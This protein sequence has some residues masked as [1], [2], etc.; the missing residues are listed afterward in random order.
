[1][2]FGIGTSMRRRGEAGRRFTRSLVPALALSLL[3]AG[4]LAPV[5]QAEDGKGLGRPDV[6][7]QRV[8]KVEKFDGPGAKKAREKVAKAKK[9]DAERARRAQAE[10][11]TGWPKQ[12]EAVV[13]LQAKRRTQAEPGGLPVSIRGAG[14]K[15]S[16][17][18]GTTARI[19]VLDRKAAKKAGITG[20]LLTAEADRTGTAQLSVDYS[21]FASAV[22]GAWSQRLRL[23]RLPA[24]VLTT[25]EK[26]KCR[27]QSPLKSDNDFA[28]QTLSADVA[29]AEA[30]SGLSSQSARS[31]AAASDTTVLAVTAAGAGSGPSPNGSGDYSA[32][33]LSASSAWQA[34][35]SSGSFTWSHDF[36][37]PPAAAGPPPEISLSYD[38]GSI[39]GRTATT[40]NQGTA[41]G[42]GFSLTESYIER[43]YG[44][45]DDDGHGDVFD[46]CWKYDNAQL[47]LD[48]KSTRLVKK[49]GTWDS[50]WRLEND[51]ASTVTRSTD[52]ANGDSNGEYWTVITGEGTKYVFGLNKLDGAGDQRTNSTWTVPVFGDDSDE[53]GYGNG[54]AFADRSETQA[55]RWNLDYVEDTHGNVT[56]YW[57]EKESNHYKKNK[58]TT[59]NASYTRGGYLK[60]IK[61]GLRKGELFTDDADAKVTFGHA[62]RCTADDCSSLT[63]D[64]AKSWPD[65]PFDAL[66]SN[67]DDECN[68]AGPSFF[69]RKRLTG[70][71]TFSWNMS[72]GAYD[73][74]DSWALNQTYRDGGD[75]GDTSDHVLTLDSIKRTGKT[76]DTNIA[77]NPISFTYQWRKNRVDGTTD[78]ILPLTHPRISTVTSETGGITAVTLSSPECVRSEVIDAAEDTNTRS[79]YPQYW[80]INGAE[81]AS[82][83]WFHK[84]R[85][86]AV[87]V[88]DPAANNDAVEHAYDYSGAAWHY[89]DDPFTPENER[90]WSD[91]RGYRQVT[92]HA[93]ATQTTRSKTV[94]LYL[95]GMD[96]DSKKDGTTRSVSIAPLAAPALGIAGITDSDQYAGQLRQQV[97]YDGASPIT[98]VVNDFWSKQTV[99]QSV[100]D[101]ADHVAR[102]VR[103]DKTTT[104]TY[105]TGPKT[106]RARAVA[107]TYDDYG[108]ATFV[109]DSGEAGKGGD[110]TCT[111]TWYARNADAG[112]TSLVS[113]S[114]TV[115]QSCSVTDAGLNLPA[116][117][118]TRGDVLADTA[119]VYDNPA[120]T[121]WVATQTPTKGAASWTGRA[122]GY[123][124]A[125]ASDGQ[126]PPSGW[127]TTAKTQYD[128]LGRQ[129]S[130]TNADDKTATTEYTPAAAGP[131][132]KTIVTNP[133]THKITS[134]LDAARGVALRVYDANLKKTEFAY[135]ALG[136]LTAVWLPNRNR[137]G[138]YSANTTYDY[139][140]SATTPSWV[141]SSTLKK[142]GTT[143]NTA[144]QLYDSLLRPLQTQTPT[145]QG[146]RLLTDTRYDTRGLAYE[147][148][149]DIFDTSSTPDGTYS[150][151]ESGESPAQAR[152]VH[153]GAGRPTT[154]TVQ[155]YGV[156]KWSTTTS[157]TGDS[158]ASTALQG[159]S[160]T[161][162]INDARGRTI[163]TRQYAGESPADAAFGT[164]P[165]SPYAATEFTHALDDQQAS[166]TGPDKTKWTYG[167]DLFGRQITV[168]DPDKGR[169]DIEYDVL[170]RVAKSTD[171]RGKSILTAYDELGRSTGTWAGSKTDANQLT[172][173]TYDSVLKG[174]AVSSTRY[175]GGKGGQAYTTTVTEFDSLSRPVGTK[176]DLPA[177]DPLVRAGAPATLTHS[178]HYNLDGT[179]QNT[180]E[181]ALGGLSSEI[182]EYGYNALGQVTSV[183]GS[184]GYL[185]DTEYSALGQAILL[186]VGTA[187]SEEH[188]KSYIS[189][190]YE[191]GTSRLLR[192]YVRDQTHSYTLQ[193]LNYS[194]DQ[195]GNV[196]SIAD[197]AD[198]GGTSAAETQCFA[199][200]GYS[201]LA[202]A[203]TPS[204]QKCSDARG[205]DNLSGP[206][207]YWT[208]YTYNDAGQR[209][210][211]TQH[212]TGGNTK[213]TYC[214]DDAR[215]HALRG[216][217][218]KADCVN[219][220]NTYR[221]DTSGNTT[222][223]SVGGTTQ[224]L[225][226]NAEG[227]VTTATGLDSTAGA[228]KGLAGKCVDVQSSQTADGT[229][230]QLYTCNDSQAQE[231]DR[232]GDTLK[233]LGKCAT[234]NGTKVELSTCDGSQAQAF[235]Q[236]ADD[237]SLYHPA[238]GKC[239]DVPSSDDTDGTDLQIYEC[240]G[241]GAQ[242]WTPSATTT[243][244]Y[245][246][247]GELLIR[248]TQD[249]ERV[250][251][252]GATELHLTA[253]NTLW[254]QRYYGSAAV[255]TNQ[256][257]TNKLTY[258]AGDHHGTSSL[259]ISADASQ[260][261]TKRHMT[262]FGAERGTPSGGSWPDDKTFL[263]KTNDTTTALV[264]IGAREYD[265]AI[266]QFI[267]VDPLLETDKPQTLN[268]YSYAANSP[269]SFTDPTGLGLACGP[270]A[271]Q[272]ACPTRPDGTQGNGRPGEA[273]DQSKPKPVRPCN[274]N[275]GGT[276]PISNTQPV[277]QPSPGPAPVLGPYKQVNDPALKTVKFA[278]SFFLPD[279]EAWKGCKEDPGIS[280]DCGSALG[281]VPLFKALKLLKLAKIKKA[282]D[283]VDAGKKADNDIK[284]KAPANCKCFLAGTDVLMADGTTKDIEDIEL[285]DKV[286]ATDPETGEAG[287]RE[288]TRLIRTEDDKHFN[289]LSIATEDGIQELTATHEHPF[290]S[291]S[292]QSWI[293]AGDLTPGMTLLTDDGDIVIVTGNRAYTQHART[294]NLTVDDLHTYYVLAGE[295]PVLVHNSGGD[296]CTPEERIEDASDIGNGHAGSKHAGDF[297][298][299]SPKDIG[300]LARD[301]MQNPARSQPLGGGRRAYQGKD[302][303]TIVIHDPMHPDGGTIF[304]RDPG[305]IDDY[306]DG[307]N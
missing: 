53:P 12:G 40:N 119:T 72:T 191:E 272:N 121:T 19:T 227:K 64:T 30:E 240:N 3:A 157:Y 7:D 1:M 130:V 155:V 49:S 20:V 62:E 42:E 237:A 24:C 76:G 111:R 93:G 298:G 58:S 148:Y 131:L 115:G 44:S 85:V 152:A 206:A 50:T 163:E 60:E 95:Q 234:V 273:V 211:E 27:I 221:Y 289:E 141:S 182:V 77:V 134:F 181:P 92:V 216:T 45:C 37:L 116:T 284:G 235:V 196:T 214:Y 83:D 217:T 5:A 300:D 233:A 123:A 288:V 118:A 172:D 305:T 114:R 262:P 125:A 249:G 170:D 173:Y 244:L 47:V 159:G 84:Y 166:I 48:G 167:Y 239:L 283:A 31:A 82:V 124:T 203:W 280:M 186:T 54:D 150:R 202:E 228:I 254:A 120:A 302:G 261:V 129:V 65:V 183:G 248:N 102:Y 281:D 278:L 293:E 232:A 33:E 299:H 103:T 133:K 241:T 274:I 187:N 225:D 145:P 195:V 210:S 198:L 4:G 242:Q 98:S 230:I 209:T 6:P 267:S 296:W 176:L 147:T 100:P 304:R 179:L 96:G 275:C 297:P 32:T 207:P 73:A 306:W 256:N 140:L 108:M 105:L 80:N 185:L 25:P 57:Y 126:R 78:N 122:T 127:Q 71:N 136:R 243:Y 99:T 174:Q 246:A 199:Y 91:W 264:H 223:R 177:G 263:G 253:D 252:A 135:D 139:R 89:S 39:D 143:Y 270:G 9:S 286:L 259:A 193:D 251:Y 279:V 257:G 15:R 16:A 90:T 107:T 34:G 245:D 168:D 229:P 38:S 132:S 290:W 18:P 307:L 153:D 197:T 146:G 142:D 162:T 266:G 87:G 260:T 17:E 29:L 292:E 303:S 276:P 56:T 164:G 236:R 2:G 110:Q 101:A 238:T 282:D 79:C 184:T 219:P 63:E 213:I 175:V 224:T 68:S 200:D 144:Y 231:W 215:P 86:L 212:K 66:C 81:N 205:A 247:N 178:S 255:R 74:V 106:W 13:E 160:A 194:Y 250:L 14:G 189:N 268:G 88:S 265:S 61:Y 294:Y 10:Q 11:K 190:K 117:S 35:G 226:W 97:T 55:W 137:A 188:K 277:P 69:S 161:R 171:S 138:G 271:N 43:T 21:G 52:A 8:S 113:R 28:D 23:V 26:P 165:G 258:L 295:T 36:F 41:V 128:T 70:V 151:A 46:R 109:D 156:E 204:S 67:G 59:A 149:A 169:T 222:V 220:A 287:P 291:P 94:S 301:V 22:G 285:G 104:H 154:T 192:S 112:I 75:I 269:V 208:G 158:T 201:R 180:Q 51:D 218:T